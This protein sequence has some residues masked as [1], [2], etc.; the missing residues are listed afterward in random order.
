MT[1]S[2]SLTTV[3]LLLPLLGILI[4]TVAAKTG[5]DA[6][7]YVQTV[8]IQKGR[9]Y[10][11]NELAQARLRNDPP[12]KIA[13][14][15]R[16]FAEHLARQPTSYTEPGRQF[17]NWDAYRYE[18]IV[19][20]GYIY[21]HDQ[22]GP[23]Y[24]PFVKDPNTGER[25]IKNVVWYPLYP[26]LGI[27]VVQLTGL[28]AH[29][30]LTLVS[31]ICIIATSLLL[32][33]F[34]RN[35]FLQ[36]L[37]HSEFSTENAESASLFTLALLLFA[38]CS[39]FLYAN[40]TESLF[41]LLLLAFLYCL[42]QKWWWR[43]AA[44]AAFAAACRSQ[45][46]LFGPL[47][48]VFYLIEPRREDDTEGGKISYIVPPVSLRAFVSSCFTRLPMA[49]GLGL[50][51]SIGIVAYML[52]LQI[53]F[54]DA[55]AFMHA[56]Y[57][58]NVGINRQTLATALNP[59]HALSD[60]FFYLLYFRPMDWPR[61]WE[62]CC[63]FWPPAVLFFGRRWLT[64][65]LAMI[66]WILWA[67]PYVSNSIAGNPPEATRW[68]SMGRFMAVLIPAQIILGAWLAGLKPAVKWKSAAAEPQA[69]AVP[70]VASV[71]S[72]S[73]NLV[74]DLQFSPR[75]WITLS[76]SLVAFTL[77]CYKFGTGEWIG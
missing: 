41:T 24:D 76:L 27:A 63:L 66:G 77:F 38:P 4:A 11:Q 44:V 13:E 39:I 34:T 73:P 55:L 21:R 2:R 36:R 71:S 12:E 26:L 74:K 50:V 67:L 51:S 3:A 33:K 32:I 19:L 62:A 6:A 70:S 42:Q 49:F 20:S 9:Y 5:Q 52:Y 46:V 28:P 7:R 59:A 1:T 65:E 29:H 16:I 23:E 17:T 45:G 14:L 54:H 18:E 37:G 60:F 43:A 48:A 15:E 25:R 8:E 58:W 10:W 61:F 35:H 30:A 69:I 31:S 53:T 40:F 75:L 68:M 72:S 22:P 64:R 56:Q 57:G 47:L